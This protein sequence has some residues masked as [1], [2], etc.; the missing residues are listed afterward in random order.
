M[1]AA[2]AAKP[3]CPIMAAAA[4]A[5]AETIEKDELILAPANERSAKAG[6]AGVRIKCKEVHESPPDG[7]DPR[8]GSG[9]LGTQPRR[10][11]SVHDWML[12]SVHI[13][14]HPSSNKL[15]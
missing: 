13:P 14:P 10:A 8:Q 15:F 2:A 11:S 6:L 5:A 9:H 12:K 3:D 7:P 4:A 1:A